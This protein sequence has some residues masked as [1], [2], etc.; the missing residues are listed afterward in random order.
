MFFYAHDSTEH[1]LRSNKINIS[2]YGA[3][4]VHVYNNACDGVLKTS[5][6]ECLYVHDKHR[7]HL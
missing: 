1:I 6:K 3:I 5:A 2:I 4:N 7:N